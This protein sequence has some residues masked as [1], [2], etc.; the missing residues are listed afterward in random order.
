MPEAEDMTN[1]A[2]HE[3][4]RQAHVLAGRAETLQDRVQLRTLL[5]AGAASPLTAAVDPAYFE[6]LRAR[7]RRPAVAAASER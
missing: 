7:V 6:G 4:G 5:L 1:R 2:H 3:D